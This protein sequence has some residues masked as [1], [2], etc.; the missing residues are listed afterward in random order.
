MLH[1]TTLERLAESLSSVDIKHFAFTFPIHWESGETFCPSEGSEF[2][3]Q[4]D[5]FGLDYTAY[6]TGGDSKQYRTLWAAGL[7]EELEQTINDDWSNLDERK[8]SKSLVAA[9]FNGVLVGLMTKYNEVEH[10]EVLSM[11]EKSGLND[12]VSDW[13]LDLLCLRVWVT[14]TVGDRFVA[15]FR[16]TNG[17]SGHVA[18]GYSASFRVGEFEFDIPLTARVRHLVQVDKTLENLNELFT[19]AKELQI[20]DK[21]RQTKAGPL[22]AKLFEVFKTPTK[23][24]AELFESLKAISDEDNALVLAVWLGDWTEKRGYKGA[25]SQML[26]IIMNEI[27]PS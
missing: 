12:E 9:T 1:G 4:F 24:Q 8:Q 17:H 27:F 21:M 15:S 13:I 11:I 26:S 22:I 2:S 6:R 16:I 7:Y 3:F 14:I 10:T 5:T 19:A 18:F 25:A 23:R 20:A